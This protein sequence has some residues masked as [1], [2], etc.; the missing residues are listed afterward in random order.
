MASKCEKMF[1]IVTCQRNTN[2]NDNEIP[3]LDCL[4]FSAIMNRIAIDMHM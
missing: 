2:Q 3:H 4:F 1:N